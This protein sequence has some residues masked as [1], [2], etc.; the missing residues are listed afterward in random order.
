MKYSRNESLYH[1]VLDEE[2]CLFDP[3]SGQYHNLN[4]VGTLIWEFLDNPKEINF[5]IKFLTNEFEV[6]KN[7]C[8]IE[9]E[10]FLNLAV[11]QKIFLISS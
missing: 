9:T 11:D 10:N 3:E 5:I 1:A 6:D 4:K 8:F 7:K 2:I